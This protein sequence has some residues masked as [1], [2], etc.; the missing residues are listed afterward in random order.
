M[1]S[2]ELFELMLARRSVRKYTGEAV[3]DEK[4]DKILKAG[5]CAPTSKNKKPWEFV[6]V[7]DK[8]KLAKLSAAKVMYGTFIKDADGAIVIVGD[9]GESDVW[10]EDCSLSAMNMMLMAHSLGVGS[11]FI[12]MGKGRPNAEGIDSDIVIRELLEIPEKYGVLCVLAL[13]VPAK[14][15][16]PHTEEN[17]PVEKI[18]KERF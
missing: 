18:H 11:C 13:G 9:E 5:L 2:N 8:D 12:Q 4:Y 1:D 6:L 7:R 3:P 15:S 14:E 17:L 10:F 16:R